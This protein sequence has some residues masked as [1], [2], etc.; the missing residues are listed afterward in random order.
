MNWVGDICVLSQLCIGID[1]K[2]HFKRGG[3]EVIEDEKNFSHPGQHVKLHKSAVE[4]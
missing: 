4:N 3:L 1:L 2:K